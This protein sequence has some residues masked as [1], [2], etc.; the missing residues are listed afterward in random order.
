MPCLLFPHISWWREV[1]NFGSL[2]TLYTGKPVRNAGYRNRYRIAT[3]GGPMLLSVPVK[4][5]RRPGTPLNETAIDYTHAWQ[6]QHWRTL[7]SAYGRAPF[8]EH[9]G[10]GL[11]SLLFAGDKWLLDLNISAI[12]WMCR[13]MRVKADIVLS[14]RLPPGAESAYWRLARPDESAAP[15]GYHQVFED[16]TGFL[17]DLSAIDLLMA[18]GPY[19]A[20][21]L[22]P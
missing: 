20:S 19:A 5:G 6:R 1:L 3:A 10:P 7:F 2:L 14:G 22:Y 13:S 9:Y 17:P 16:R 18:E 12:E 15:L 21:F 11:E 8:F 4:G